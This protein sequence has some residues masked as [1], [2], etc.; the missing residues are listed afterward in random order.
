MNPIQPLPLTDDA[1][2]AIEFAKRTTNTRCP[3]MGEAAC[4]E[5]SYAKVGS[6]D[7]RSRYESFLAG[8]KASSLNEYFPLL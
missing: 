1:L 4:R 3:S 5:C 8:W 6:C 2:A 7:F